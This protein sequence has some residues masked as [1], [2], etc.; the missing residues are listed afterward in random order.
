M[1]ILLVIGYYIALRT[2]NK[3]DIFYRLMASIFKRES[4]P[5][6]DELTIFSNKLFKNFSRNM[7]VLL[8]VA[9]SLFMAN[10]VMILIIMISLA[11]VTKE[12]RVG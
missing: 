2:E 10:V 1:L 12:Y 3:K 11:F 8:K 9:L 7:T 5:E 6:F 4:P